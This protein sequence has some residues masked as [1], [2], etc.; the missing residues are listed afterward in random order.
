MD[1]L[2]ISEPIESWIQN[3]L[4]QENHPR[5]QKEKIS[6]VSCWWRWGTGPLLVTPLEYGLYQCF[7]CIK[8]KSWVPTDHPYGNLY[9][10]LS[11]GQTNSYHI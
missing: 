5:E 8:S 6:S 11:R 2:S 1:M 7:N 4:E 3:P 9:C 10:W